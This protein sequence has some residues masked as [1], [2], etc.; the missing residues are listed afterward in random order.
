MEYSWHTEFVVGIL[1][2]NPRTLPENGS[3]MTDSANVLTSRTAWF[4]WPQ[5]LVPLV[6]VALSY[7]III[8]L[9]MSRLSQLERQATQ[10]LTKAEY[11]REEQQTES[12]LKVL[13]KLPTF[14]FD[15]LIA[16]WAFLNFL[17]YFGDDQARPQ[18]G[19]R[20]VPDFFQLIVARDPRFLDIYPYLSA[21][22]T[23]YGGQPQKTVQLLQ[24]G[25]DAVHPERQADA[26]FL[27]QA[28]ATD[29]LLFL[30]RNKDAQRSYEMAGSWASRS[31]DPALQN[32]ATRSRQTAQ[33]LAS[34]P[35]SRRARVGAWFNILTNAI[36]DPTR[37][38]AV[39]Q[40]QALGGTISQENGALKV[41]LPQ[42]D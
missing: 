20:M 7:G 24:Q 16:D 5:L 11:I 29:E 35:D 1:K 6:L 12:G 14:G 32:I 8:N 39:R 13:A 41:S 18:T 3:A 36:D 25:I 15:N 28:K 23:L 22:V 33:F 17:Q 42:K 37:R 4:R 26:Y 2:N 21:G 38:F 9:Q 40:I 31:Q 19:Y 10:S 34:N 27:W 30:G